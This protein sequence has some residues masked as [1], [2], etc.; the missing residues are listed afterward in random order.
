[1]LSSV[2][3]ILMLF[4]RGGDARL[5]VVPAERQCRWKVGLSHFCSLR[6]PIERLQFLFGLYAGGGHGGEQEPL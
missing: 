5:R 1:M 6:L 3:L 4:E 2:A